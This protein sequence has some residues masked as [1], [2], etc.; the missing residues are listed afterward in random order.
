MA[1]S[2]AV[3]GYLALN[4]DGAVGAFLFDFVFVEVAVVDSLGVAVK[5]LLYVQIGNLFSFDIQ[6]NDWSRSWGCLSL[7]TDAKAK[8]RTKI[9]N[10]AVKKEVRSVLFDDSFTFRVLLPKAWLGVPSHQMTPTTCL[11]PPGQQR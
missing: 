7:V 6:Q 11:R 3:L 4:D 9:A 5:K 2:V 10:K 1:V 8:S